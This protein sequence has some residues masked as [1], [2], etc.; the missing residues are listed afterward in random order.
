VF[1]SKGRKREEKKNVQREEQ[2]DGGT[3]PQTHAILLADP[4]T[5]LALDQEAEKTSGH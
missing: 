3:C 1:G 5:P 4:S 2:D